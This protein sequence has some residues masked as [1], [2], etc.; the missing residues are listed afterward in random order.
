M[1][2]SVPFE[3]PAAKELGSGEIEYKT[4][5]SRTSQSFCGVTSQEHVDAFQ[6]METKSDA[7]VGT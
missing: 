6:S 7:L 1:N 4:L 2:S 3:Q 5:R